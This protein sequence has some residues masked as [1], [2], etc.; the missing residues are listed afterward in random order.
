MEAGKERG[1]G[2]EGEG[3]Q[4]ARSHLCGNL[5]CHPLFFGRWPGT[6]RKW[7][8]AYMLHYYAGENQLKKL[9]HEL[10]VDSSKVC[11]AL[12]LFAGVGVIRGPESDA[13]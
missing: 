9:R 3:N 2:E 10:H 6:K 4:L 8:Q 1:V 5:R 12:P 11:A 7:L 13:S